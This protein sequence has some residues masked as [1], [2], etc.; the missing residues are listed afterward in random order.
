MHEP[1]RRHPRSALPLFLTALALAGCVPM[2]P[3]TVPLRTVSYPG[4]GAPRTLV[5][6]LPGQRDDP[7]DFGRQRFPEI[8]AKAGA[9]VDMIAVDAHMAYYY[10]HTIVDRLRADV[11]APARKRYDHVW[12]VGI[13][14]G[15][16]GALLYVAQHPEDVDG[17]ILLAP[18]LGEERVLAEVRTAGGPRSWKPPEPLAADDFQRQMWA[19]IAR[20]AAGSPDHPPLYLGY[21]QSDSFAG[22]NGMMGE[23][24]PTGRVFTTP[25]G[26]KW[27]TWQTLWEKIAAAGALPG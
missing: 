13:S 20:Y 27:K 9:K 6:L 17:L 24:L 21:G 25:G 11:I 1:I 5:V 12:L 15:G 8:A 23:A 14:I 4:A 7:E 22:P 2:R 3:E 18:Y 10:D 16:T 19:W 26:H